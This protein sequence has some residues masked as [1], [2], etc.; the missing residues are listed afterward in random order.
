MWLI[1]RLVGHLREVLRWLTRPDPRP[2]EGGSLVARWPAWTLAPCARAPSTPAHP[3]TTSRAW[4]PAPNTVHPRG[5]TLCKSCPSRPLACSATPPSMPGRRLHTTIL[6]PSE[7]MR[8]SHPRSARQGFARGRSQPR[9]Q[10]VRVLTP[11][12]VQKF[13]EV[14]W[15]LAPALFPKSHIGERR[16][17]KLWGV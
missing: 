15:P 12:H 6:W 10:L 16:L 4:V 3:G 11:N 7:H 5:P 9:G 17:R 14:F 2:D 13:L 1:S 8:S